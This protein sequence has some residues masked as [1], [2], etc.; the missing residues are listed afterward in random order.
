VPLRGNAGG[1]A[2][3]SNATAG[4]G[5]RAPLLACNQEWQP[6]RASPITQTRVIGCQEPERKRR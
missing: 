4:A 6:G 1:A 3:K 5:S 2:R